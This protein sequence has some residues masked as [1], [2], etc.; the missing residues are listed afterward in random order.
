MQKCK[1][2]IKTICILKLMMWGAVH[3][4]GAIPMVHLRPREV[5]NMYDSLSLSLQGK[6]AVTSSLAGYY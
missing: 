1:E 6:Q 2:Y 3:T 4:H 5:H